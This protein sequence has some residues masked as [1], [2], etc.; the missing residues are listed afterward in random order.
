MLATVRVVAHAIVA[1]VPERSTPALAEADLPVPV[2]SHLASIYQ[3]S[4]VESRSA[5]VAR[6]V[7]A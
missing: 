6:W 1:L 5:A 3:K 7:D 2:R 4:G